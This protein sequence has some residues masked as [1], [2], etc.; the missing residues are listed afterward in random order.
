M[1]SVELDLNRQNQI[2]S[3]LNNSKQIF[4]TTTSVEN[5]SRKILNDSFVIHQ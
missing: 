3:L 2:I 5:L 4:I 1:Y